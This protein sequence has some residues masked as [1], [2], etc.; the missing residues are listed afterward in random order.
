MTRIVRLSISCFALLNT[1]S[2]QA[3]PDFKIRYNQKFPCLEVMDSKAVKITDVT[4]GAK[5]ET[6]TS[7][8]AS[9]NISFIK[10]ADGQPEVTLREAKSPLSEMEIEAFG[11][12]VGL[13]PEG[14][15]MVRFGADN[16]PKF[17]MD[18]TGGSR[19]LMAD[20]GNLDTAAGKELA[21]DAAITPPTGPSK[22]LIR[23]RERFADWKAANG[24][25]GWSNRPGKILE[26]GADA[27]VTY[28]GLPERKLLDGEAIQTG[29]QVK[30]GPT[31]AVSFQ[32]GP[33]IFHTAM[34]GT[35]LSVAPLE[36]GQKDVKVTLLEGALLTDVLVPLTAPRILVLGLGNGLVVQTSNGLFQISKTAT[37]DANLVVSEG[38]IRL[39]QEAGAAQVAEVKAGNLL[40]WPTDKTAKA[41]A[42]GSPEMASLA[43]EK[44]DARESLLTDMAEDAIKST[45]TDA[46]EIIRT[47]CEAEVKLARKIASEAVEIRPDL[48][49]LI[50]RVSGVTDLPSP[51]NSE[52]ATS[53]FSKLAQPWLR[54]EPSPA[55]AIGK[56]LRV[57]GKATYANGLPLSRSMLLKVG[58]VVKTA[59]D[60]RV[61]FVAAPGVIA[62]I[63]PGSEVRLV[64]M[65]GRFSNGELDE[66]RVILHASQGDAFLSI[67]QGFGDKI[68]AEVRTPQGVAKA[69][70][71]T[72]STH[73]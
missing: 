39:V 70:S 27:T 61:L 6:V 12:S 4:E 15:V 13:K 35:L 3:A 62:E 44:Q 43:K 18:R 31:S 52:S 8:K 64:E 49:D 37:G 48:H 32:S 10:N 14:T 28:T 54:G 53:A 66:S 17:E 25:G 47:V 59:G 71:T 68:Q 55:S 56:V 11:L 2:L 7:G 20:L 30:V 45:P 29:A 50:A 34:P 63:Q 38:A 40:R 58:E 69:K 16:K 24:K 9:L 57:E 26:C 5:G 46:E 42:A 41:M 1:W 51:V 65:K 23:F 67:L 60:G 72:G 73:L 19:F 36:A 21:T 33:G 22:G